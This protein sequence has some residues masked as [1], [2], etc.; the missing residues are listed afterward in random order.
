MATV[1][2]ILMECEF[3]ALDT[4]IIEAIATLKSGQSE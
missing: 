2:D 4:Y 3:Q 1:K